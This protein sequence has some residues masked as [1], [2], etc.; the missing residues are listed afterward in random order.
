MMRA[1]LS[2]WL[3]AALKRLLDVSMDWA[4]RSMRAEEWCP[5]GMQ[6]RK[7]VMEQFEAA[8]E[9]ALNVVTNEIRQLQRNRSHF[10]RDSARSG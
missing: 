10:N 6:D 8:R 7:V 3:G 5:E 4:L 9:A 2:D 1:M